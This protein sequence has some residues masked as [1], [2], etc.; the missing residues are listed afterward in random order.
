MAWT[1]V[2]ET[3]LL[4]FTRVSCEHCVKFNPVL[5]DV[6]SNKCP[7]A[8]VVVVSLDRNAQEYSTTMGACGVD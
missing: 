2:P 7:Q 3:L 1:S 6:V 5:L 4:Y 8:K